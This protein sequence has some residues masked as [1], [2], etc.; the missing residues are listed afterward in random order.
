MIKGAGSQVGAN[1]RL[2]GPRQGD[3]YDRED[4]DY[5]GQRQSEY[6]G[7]AYGSMKQGA[8]PSHN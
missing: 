4:E 6:D 5:H 7:Q 2:M 8:S 1:K 3:Y